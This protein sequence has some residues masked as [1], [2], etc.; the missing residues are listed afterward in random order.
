MD[1]VST[2]KRKMVPRWRELWRTS[3]RELESHTKQISNNSI[4][5]YLFQRF[6]FLYKVWQESPTLENAADVV[7]AAVPVKDRNLAV[8]PAKQLS[9]SC[10]NS[11]AIMDVA[12]FVLGEPRSRSFA[13]SGVT[14]PVVDKWTRIALLKKITRSEPRNALA[15]VEKCR[16]YAE[17]GNDKAGKRAADFALANAPDNRFVLR[18][19]CRFF[20]HIG[21]I[22][23]AHDIVRKSRILKFDPW[24]Q[25]AEIS[26]AEI[27]ERHP[28]SIR[29][30]RR[31]LSEA[32]FEE[33][34]ISELAASVGTLEASSGKR[35]LANRLL[36]RSLIDPTDNSLSQ[37]Y[38]MIDQDKLRFSVDDKKLNMVGSAEARLY[39]SEIQSN[40][41][42]AVD[43]SNEWIDDEPFSLRAAAHGSSIATGILSD[44]MQAIDFCDRG[45][46]A[47]P[48][49]LIL[50]NNKVVALCRIGDLN[51]AKQWI[52]KLRTCGEENED[53]PAVRATLGL[54]A[55]RSGSVMQGR[56]YYFEAVQAGHKIGAPD[57]EFRA[58]IH[59]AYEEVFANTLNH[60]AVE[61][62]VNLLESKMRKTTL[63][64]MTSKLWSLKKKRMLEF[65]PKDSPIEDSIDKKLLFY[66]Q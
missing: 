27:A 4:D 37:A 29:Y 12:S 61:Q 50:I 8:G 24:I 46:T 15:W 11:P 58:L 36:K 48:G 44:H 57:T 32:K 18:S 66:L 6:H 65:Q 9:R 34:H 33:F 7:D 19:I 1:R 20:V 3:S 38:W 51:D 52:P 43:A 2:A 49:N 39:W 21:D 22:E 25:A 23:R 60:N 41:T 55:F 59:W 45:L 53:F 47:N 30:A 26:L 35:R 17:L 64:R 56:Q 42:S 10:E 31:C 40:W 16:L 5:H 62:L 54:F 28:S 63:S 14:T 13:T